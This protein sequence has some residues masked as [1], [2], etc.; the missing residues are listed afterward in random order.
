M[1]CKQCRNGHHDRA[2]DPQAGCPGGT[3]CDCQHAE[4]GINWSLVK[5]PETVVVDPTTKPVDCL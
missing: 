4:S 2:V 5:T 1:I 3:W